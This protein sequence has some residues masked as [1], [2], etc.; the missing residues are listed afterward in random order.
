MENPPKPNAKLKAALKLYQKAKRDDAGNTFR[1]ALI[2][3][4]TPA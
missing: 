4:V 2:K 3:S 1:D